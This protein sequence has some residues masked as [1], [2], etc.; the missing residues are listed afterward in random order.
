MGCHVVNP[1]A[2]LDRTHRV[3]FEADIQLLQELG[4]SLRGQAARYELAETYHTS[5]ETVEHVLSN[6]GEAI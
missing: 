2:R 6:L 5:P 1:N 3:I 4:T